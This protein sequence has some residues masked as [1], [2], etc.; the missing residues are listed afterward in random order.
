MY[1]ATSDYAGMITILYY[2]SMVLIPR[3]GPVRVVP[4]PRY[5]VVRVVCVDIKIPVITRT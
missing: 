1:V 3:Y 2:T 4:I 5:G